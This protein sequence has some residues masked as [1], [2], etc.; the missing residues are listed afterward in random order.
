[1]S[2]GG[3]APNKL[4]IVNDSTKTSQKLF[5][6]RR[7]IEIFYI[8]VLTEDDLRQNDNPELAAELDPQLADVPDPDRAIF[9]RLS[10]LETT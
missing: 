3:R 10:D 4:E 7:E 9:V 1:V 8:R 5:R 6:P 2:R